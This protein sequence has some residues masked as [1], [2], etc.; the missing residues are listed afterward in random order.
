[1]T[2]KSH[3]LGPREQEMM[4]EIRALV[5]GKYED[6]GLTKALCVVSHVAGQIIAVAKSEGKED[7]VAN[8]VSENL[9]EGTRHGLRQ[10]AEILRNMR[11]G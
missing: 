11:K 7:D 8:L 4:G 5:F 3:K 10:L 2:S 1:M 6:I 9:A